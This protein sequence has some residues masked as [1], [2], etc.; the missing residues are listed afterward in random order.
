MENLQKGKKLFLTM[1]IVL[2]AT[3]LITSIISS[4]SQGGTELIQ[5]II[6]TGLEGLLLYYIFKGKNWAKIIMIVL[7]ALGILV[8]LIAV[9]F[10]MNIMFIILLVVD[11]GSLYILAFSPVVKEYLKSVNN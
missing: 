1:T 10:S 11:G 5:G 2:L 6:R 3:S 4:F 9:I 8:A 7:L